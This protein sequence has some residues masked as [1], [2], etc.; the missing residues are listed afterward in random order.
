MDQ[1]RRNFHQRLEHKAPFMQTRMRQH[2]KLCIALDLT[3]EQQ[4]EIDRAWAILSFSRAAE[5]KFDSQQPRHHL[6]RRRQRIPDFSDHIK[7]RWLLN[8]AE[9]LSLID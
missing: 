6:F 5:E 9:R 1:V 8:F 2:Q 7:K 3:I 4:I